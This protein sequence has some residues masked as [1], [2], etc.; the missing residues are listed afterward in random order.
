MALGA[1]SRTCTRCCATTRSSAAPHD[2]STQLAMRL[3]AAPRGV[4]AARVVFR[5]HVGDEVSPRQL[6]RVLKLLKRMDACE[7][8]RD[9]FYAARQIKGAVDEDAFVRTAMIDV[10]GRCGRVD[11]AMEH[12]RSLGSN[13]DVV[14]CNAAM[15]SCIKCK[16][17]EMAQDI[18]DTMKVRDGASY[19]A[20]MALH[21]AKG[22][23]EEAVNCLKAMEENGWEPDKRAWTSAI[24]AMAKSDAWE[25]AVLLF[26]QM[27]AR[28]VVADTPA[29]NALLHAVAR[30][31]Q[32]GLT[33][34]LFQTMKRKNVITNI[35][36][37][38]ILLDACSR[39]E[40]WE[41]AWE[42]FHDMGDGIEPDIV[43]YNSLISALGA[44]G[45]WEKAAAVFQEVEQRGLRPDVI[46]YTALAAAFGRGR[47]TN[48]AIELLDR[49]RD[50]GTNPNIRT[51]NTVIE[52]CLQSRK[53]LF[54][55]S[56]LAELQE[57]GLQPDR[58]TYQ[59]ALASFE[60]E[61][62]W[63]EA[64]DIFLIMREKKI[65]MDSAILYA[66]Q[67]LYAWPAG[68]KR[69]PDP[70]I[71]TA[72]AAVQSGR[73]AR[74]TIPDSFIQIMKSTIENGRAARAAFENMRT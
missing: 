37:Y 51:Y 39:A 17:Y 49:M 69:V 6:A 31:R 56:L 9:A 23:W 73:D 15:R 38:N 21:A 28:G 36:T 16:R 27:Q 65:P 4:R 13:P 18:W 66:R 62:L 5:S 58:V 34:D 22:Q 50:A 40:K 59:L 43:S 7:A 74:A 72:R 8:A 60:R 10:C 29:W 1:L 48:K 46:T 24:V 12:F 41:V 42:I 25:D 35:R 33:L 20:M 57:E 11:E 61:S 14:S 70:V 30:G 52:A 26:D 71:A 2:I 63:E 67:L 32:F 53:P 3:A 55:Q 44:G 68:L 54:V 45:Q 47:Q 64:A 19:A